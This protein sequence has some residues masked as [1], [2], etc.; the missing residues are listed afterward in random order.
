MN[1]VTRNTEVYYKPPA[2]RRISL[3]CPPPDSPD[4]L[5]PRQLAEART[6]NTYYEYE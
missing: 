6:S 1:T 5:G 4:R 3:G 2:L